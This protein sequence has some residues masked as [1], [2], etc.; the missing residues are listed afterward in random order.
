MSKNLIHSSILSG[1]KTENFG[2]LR[3][4]NYGILLLEMFS[5]SKGQLGA[6]VLTFHSEEHETLEFIEL[7]YD[8]SGCYLKLSLLLQSGEKMTAEEANA[9]CS[10]AEINKDGKLDY[11][12]VCSRKLTK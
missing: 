10:L 11:A 7:H 12:E 8:R 4:E 2:K 6:P 1:L 3:V 9:V 5:S